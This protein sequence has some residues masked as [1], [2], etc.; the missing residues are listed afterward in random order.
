ML[1]TITADQRLKDIPAS[2]IE[3][4]LRC[5]VAGRSLVAVRRGRQKAKAVHLELSAAQLQK[6]AA[7]TMAGTLASEL[8]QLS[9][10][11][12]SLVQHGPTVGS[13]RENLLQTLLRK[14]LPERYHVATG[15]IYH[16]NR[17]L[18]I[19]IYDR[20]DYAPVFREG[21]LVVVHPESVRAVIEV[22]TSLNTAALKDSLQL[23][24]DVCP[25]DDRDPPFFKG[26]FAFGSRMSAKSMETAIADFYITDDEAPFD[27]VT[28]NSI[29]QPF[30]HMTALCVLEKLYT[31][32]EYQAMDDDRRLVPSLFSYTSGTGLKPQATHFVEKLLAY[33]RT[34]G[35]KEHDVRGMTQ[36]LG[37]DTQVKKVKEL[38]GASWGG[39]FA[40]DEDI[41]DG[42]EGAEMAARIV[43]VQ[44][45]LAGGRYPR[46]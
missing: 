30:D 16:C 29:G 10:R 28:E 26:I 21:D 33:L 15:F 39:Y 12:R 36:I 37:M 11:I 43:A 23:L 5:G 8:V 46:A 35:L 44:Q 41:G 13:Y 20:I 25:F 31:E 9:Q 24:A 7:R 19:V 38:T 14:H 45:W 22:K 42:N 34:D 6:E 18:D 1:T 4:C 3:G 32:V 2:F 40:D 17:Q 27:I